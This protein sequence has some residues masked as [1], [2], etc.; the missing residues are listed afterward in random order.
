[1][2]RKA[3][4]F[5]AWQFQNPNGTVKDAW[6]AAWEGQNALQYSRTIQRL[7]ADVNAMKGIANTRAEIIAEQNQEIERLKSES[8]LLRTGDTCA[9]HCECVAF[10]HEAQRLRA[11][12]DNCKQVVSKLL[13]TQREDVTKIERLNRLA[14]LA[15][16]YIKD[17]EEHEGAEGFSASTWELSA[18]YYAALAGKEEKT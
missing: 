4:N 5:R 6:N 16:A 3:N 2:S 8:A 13:E 10:R 12:W 14:A 17:L 7:E 11:E 1:M 18:Q 9:R 15:S